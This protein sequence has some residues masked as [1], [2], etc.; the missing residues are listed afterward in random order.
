MSFPGTEVICLKG[1]HEQAAL[2]FLDRNADGSDWLKYGGRE[3]LSSYGV[4]TGRKEGDQ[5]WLNSV[6]EAFRAAFPERHLAFLKS[7]KLYWRYGD[8]LFV[9]AGIDPALSLENQ[10]EKELLWI[11][12]PFL[13]SVRKLPFIVVHGHTPEVKPVWDG[14]RIGVDTGAYISNILTAVKLYKG[15][16]SFLAT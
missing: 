8:Y 10:T 6:K 15:E 3:T 14:R 7:L 11:R 9:H 12:G 1:N 13:N 16:V 2:E 4:D 5:A